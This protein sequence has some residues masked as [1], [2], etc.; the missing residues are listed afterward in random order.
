[1]NQINLYGWPRSVEQAV[2]WLIAMMEPEQKIQVAE[3]TKENLVDLQYGLG[4]AIRNEFGLWSDNQDLLDDCLLLTHSP[5]YARD[6]GD[7]AVVRIHPDDAS[8]VILE[9]LWDRLHH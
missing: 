9:A 5:L 8:I 3:L 6:A 4:A 7:S 1:M 2:D